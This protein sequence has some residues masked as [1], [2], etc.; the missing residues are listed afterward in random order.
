[1]EGP[2]PGQWPG[3]RGVRHSSRKTDTNGNNGQALPAWFFYGSAATNAIPEGQSRAG[4]G[5]QITQQL[6]GHEGTEKASRC[7]RQIL[8][9]NGFPTWIYVQGTSISKPEHILKTK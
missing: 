4:T 7:G 2:S 9:A 6:M 1:M 8:T 3:N 5:I